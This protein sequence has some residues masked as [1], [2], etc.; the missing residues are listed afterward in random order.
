[1]IIAL[2]G[3]NEYADSFVS[4]CSVATVRT[5]KHLVT[6]FAEFDHKSARCSN[7]PLPVLL[8]PIVRP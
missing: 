1:V 8:S 5:M 4:I 3:C 6:R 7:V 2:A